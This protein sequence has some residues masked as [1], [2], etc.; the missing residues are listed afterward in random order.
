MVGT[1]A[2]PPPPPPTAWAP[3]GAPHAAGPRRGAGGGAG[4]ARGPGRRK[5]CVKPPSPTLGGG[6]GPAVGRG[7]RQRPRQMTSLHNCLSETA[8]S[9]RIL[10]VRKGVKQEQPSQSRC[11]AA[12]S[13]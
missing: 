4:G 9:E 3:A 8:G 13:T 5:G 10:R 1:T 11:R 12:A 6:G 2:P 7:A